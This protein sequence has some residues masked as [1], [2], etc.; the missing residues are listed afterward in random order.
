MTIISAL[1]ISFL[2][3]LTRLGEID[4]SD[5]DTLRREPGGRVVGLGGRV[6]RDANR[7]SVTGQRGVAGWDDIGADHHVGR[8]VEAG[9]GVNRSR[10]L[11]RGV[12]CAPHPRYLA[13]DD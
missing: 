11:S 1:L 9:Q 7:P 3:H 6:A 5:D 8:S 4:S 12:P 2:Q 10:G 13:S